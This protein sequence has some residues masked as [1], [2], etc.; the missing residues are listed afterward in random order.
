MLYSQARYLVQRIESMY[1]NPFSPRAGSRNTWPILLVESHIVADLWTA[2]LS[3][4]M[5]GSALV[6]VFPYLLNSF[7]RTCE[8]DISPLRMPV[9]TR[10]LSAYYLLPYSRTPVDQQVLGAR[11]GSAHIAY[12]FIC[13]ARKQ[14]YH[15]R[16]RSTTLIIVNPNDNPISRAT[17]AVVI[18]F[19]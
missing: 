9:R 10:L 6:S 18:A 11:A 8:Y 1:S 17:A 16:M 14:V 15:R 4:R 19:I 3:R 5:L 13:F 12:F 2:H 7:P